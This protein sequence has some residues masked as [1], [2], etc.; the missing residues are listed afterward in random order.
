MWNALPKGL[1]VPSLF[2]K[3]L[4]T[5]EGGGLTKDEDKLVKFLEVAFYYKKESAFSMVGA[6]AEHILH[7][8][9]GGGIGFF[10][11]CVLFLK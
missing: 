11:N 2:P 7:E 9:D 4:L 1:R 10:V 6:S 3:P 5:L 8:L